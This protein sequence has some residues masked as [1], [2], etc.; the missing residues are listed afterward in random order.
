MA[1]HHI[2]DKKELNSAETKEFWG[3]LRRVKVA[4][5]VMIWLIRILHFQIGISDNILYVFLHFLQN[6]L[7]TVIF[8]QNGNH[9][10]FRMEHCVCYIHF[11]LG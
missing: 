11:T 1:W 3:N 9:I 7:V 2:W 5:F 10:L 4:F 8:I 6:K